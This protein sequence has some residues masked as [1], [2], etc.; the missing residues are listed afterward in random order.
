MTKAMAKKKLFIPNKLKDWDEARQRFRLSHVHVQM[1]RELGMNPKKL[2]KLNNHHQERWKLPLPDFITKLYA[3]RFGKT[4]P[5]TVRTIRETATA[6]AAKKA[7]RRTRKALMREALVQFETHSPCFLDYAL[8]PEAPNYQ[9]GTANEEDP[10]EDEIGPW[11][12]WPCVDAPEIPEGD[13]S[14]SP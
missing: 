12:A 6:T 1:A 10:R 14:R 8:I 13:P 7:A 3:K 5:D 2:G 11:Q 4:R 9:E